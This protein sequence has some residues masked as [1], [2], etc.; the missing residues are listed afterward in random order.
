MD[1]KIE[2]LKLLN[3]LKDGG[4]LKNNRKWIIPGEDEN[5]QTGHYDSIRERILNNEISENMTSIFK[6]FF[7]FK[8]LKDENVITEEEF[9]KIRYDKIGDLEFG[10]GSK[11]I[12]EDEE[13]EEYKS[14]ERSSYKPNYKTPVT[15]NSIS[16]NKIKDELYRMS[17]DPW[18]KRAF[19]NFKDA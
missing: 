9:E 18:V 19:K 17:Y 11:L 12:E 10:G 6:D 2:Q 14:T 1:K 7:E 8:K 5:D 16:S 13:N 15:L 3:Q 4:F